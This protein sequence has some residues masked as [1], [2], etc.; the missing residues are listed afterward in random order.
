[1]QRAAV[2]A[3]NRPAKHRQNGFRVDAARTSLSLGELSM[4]RP[5]NPPE[6]PEY[7]RNLK[8]QD[9]ALGHLKDLFEQLGGDSVGLL[10]R[11][12]AE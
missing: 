4:D 2:S 5:N 1:L 3:G 9:G 10:D 7:P 8:K 12:Q 6:P 11:F